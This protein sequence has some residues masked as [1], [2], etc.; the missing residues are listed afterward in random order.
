MLRAGRVRVW[1]PLFSRCVPAR[2][3][4]P[5]H[6]KDRQWTVKLQQDAEIV[7]DNL[8]YTDGS[9][10]GWHWRGARAAYSGVCYSAEGVP[11]WVLKGIC[12]EPHAS[13]NRAELRAVLEVMRLSVGDVTIKS[14]SAFVVRGFKVEGKEACTASWH[15]AAD[16]W[17]EGWE[18]FEE[19]GGRVSVEKVRAHTTWGDVMEGEVTHMDFVG[20]READRAAKEALKVA[21]LEAPA[22][23]YNSALAMAVLWGKWVMDYASA[24]D[25]NQAEEEALAEEAWEREGAEERENLEATR[26]SL[27]H[28]LWRGRGCVVCRRCGRESTMHRPIHTFGADACKGTAAGRVMAA[29]TGNINFLW[30]RYRYSVIE[31]AVRGLTQASTGAIPQAA[32]DEERIDEVREDTGVVGGAAA[33]EGEEPPGDDGPRAGV[34]RTVA[35]GVAR[36]RQHALRTRGQLT[37]CDACGAYSHQRAGRRIKG[38]CVGAVTRHRL[39]RLVRLRAGKHPISGAVLEG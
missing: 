33:E 23:A 14:D 22:E 18:I 26:N 15:E 13:I 21:K 24:W 20:N 34:T 8:V 29:G 3:K 1:D 38:D 31:M 12:G 39:T 37:W 10:E 19:L 6:P 36:G 9:A 4:V 28:E 35:V 30:S 17:R 27:A 25:P 32:I 2:P 16:L 7:A 5:P 11:M